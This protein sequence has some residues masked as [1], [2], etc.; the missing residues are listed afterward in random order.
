MM[1]GKRNFV[2]T[3][4]C[5]FQHLLYFLNR[6]SLYLF[7]CSFVCFYFCLVL[8]VRIFISN[9]DA[10]LFS[11]C[12]AIYNS[13]SGFD[14][15]IW[16]SVYNI[17]S[18]TLLRANG[19]RSLCCLKLTAHFHLLPRSTMR[20]AKPPLPNTRSWHSSQLKA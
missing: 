20:G 1:L 19:L 3:D 4:V 8:D 9:L 15:V 11:C 17:L 10:V 13:S 7:L 6:W 5:Q 18:A 16:S 2:S 12:I 14:V